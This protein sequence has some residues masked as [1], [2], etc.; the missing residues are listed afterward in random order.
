M[1]QHSIQV[2]QSNQHN[3]LTNARF[4]MYFDNDNNIRNNNSNKAQK[5]QQK[6]TSE[7]LNP[8]SELYTAFQQLLLEEDD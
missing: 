5:K 3:P 1:K 4:R 2:S 7:R 8:D 6:Q